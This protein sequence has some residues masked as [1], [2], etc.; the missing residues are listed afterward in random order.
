MYQIFVNTSGTDLLTAICVLRFFA[1]ANLFSINRD[2]SRRLDSQSHL[3]AAHA[4]NHDFNIVAD[5]Q[6]F[7]GPSA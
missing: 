1:L 7:A 3:I 2:I 5:N 6:D 4:E